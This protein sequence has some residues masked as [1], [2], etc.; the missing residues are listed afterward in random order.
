MPS[1]GGIHS[2]KMVAIIAVARKLLTFLNA[3][4]RDKQPW[5]PENA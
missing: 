2:I 5:R 1:G 3:I 4:L